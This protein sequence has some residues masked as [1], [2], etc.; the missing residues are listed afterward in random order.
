MTEQP[1][2]EAE[3]DAITD[4]AAHWCMRLH[5]QDCTAAER[6][7]FDAWLKADPLHASEYEAMLEIWDV[8]EHLPRPPQAEVIPLP[9]KRRTWSRHGVAASSLL[10]IPLAGYIGWSLGWIPTSYQTFEAGNQVEHVTLAD[11]S[12]VELNLGSQLT[13][14]NY[15]D[16]RRVTLKKGEAF[17]DVSHDAEHPFVVK[18]A[19]GQI[20]VTGTRFNVWMYEDQVRVTLLQGSVLVSSDSRQPSGYRLDPGMQARYKAGDFEPQISQTYANDTSLA[21]RNGKLILDNLSLADA[22]PLINRYL[23]TPVLLA[24]P[25]TGGIRIGGIYSTAEVKKLVTSL[26]KVLPVYLTQNKDGNPVLNSI[27]QEKPKA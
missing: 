17:F 16:Q 6:A 3:Y 2:S 1:L 13:Y 12:Q 11:G 9:V 23:A 15:R 21:W 19:K 10:A 18:A 24:D 4:A 25:A 27:P 8:A 14:S 7:E 22:L 26:P 20:R 5:E